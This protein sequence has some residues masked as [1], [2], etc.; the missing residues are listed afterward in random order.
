MRDCLL[1][2]QDL[3]LKYT[4]KN[5]IIWGHVF[6]GNVHFVLTPDLSDKAE[7]LKYKQFMD[8][9][10]SLVV[11]KYDGSLKAEHGTGRNMAPFVKREWGDQ[12]YGIMR[13]IKALFD[14]DCRSAPVGQFVETET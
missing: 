7:I 3:F 8:E 2:L 14:P 6:D 13:E 4:Y 11:G 10:A 12:I 9:L 5:T 1:D